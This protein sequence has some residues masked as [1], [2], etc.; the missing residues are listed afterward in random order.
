M[1]LGVTRVTDF[2]ECADMML[3]ATGFEHRAEEENQGIAGNSVPETAFDVSFFCR[4]LRRVFLFFLSPGMPS[5]RFSGG[6][7]R[8][9]HLYG[10]SMLQVNHVLKTRV[11]EV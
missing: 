11:D 4:R 5:F 2:T 3:I 7:K 1:R 10:E 8:P 9:C 6:S